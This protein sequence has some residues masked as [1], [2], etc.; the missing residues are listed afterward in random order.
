VRGSLAALFPAGGSRAACV[1]LDRSYSMGTEG[2]GGVLFDRGVKRLSAIL[3]NLESGDEVSVVLFDTSTE[4][5]YDGGPDREAVLEALRDARPSWGG[6]DLRSAAA[7]GERILARSRR[8]ARELYIVSDFQKTAFA[9]RGAGARAAAPE[10]SRAPGAPAAESRRDLPVRAFLLPVQAKGA[11]N[12]AVESVAA[13]SVALHKGETAELGITLRNRSRE[14]AAKFPLEV[15]IAGRRVLEKEIEIPP[16]GYHTEKVVF[17]AE[18]SGWIDGVVRKRPDRLSADDARYFALNV[19]D[20]TRVLLLADDGGFYLEQALV[21]GGIEGDIA[22]AKRAWR[23]F[24]SAD[25]GA[26]DAVVLGPGRGPSP[27]DVEIIGRF[28]ER[29]GKAIVFLVPELAAAAKRL[30]GYPLAIEFAEMPQGFFRLAKPE[31]PPDFLAPFDE[32]DL[33][34]FARLRFRSA[35]LVRGVPPAEARLSFEGRGPFVWEERRGEGTVVFAAADPRPEAGELVLSPFFLPLV[36]QLVLATG[37]DAPASQGSL[38]GEPIVWTG[39]T[40]GEVTCLLPD[41]AT[42]RPAGAPGGILIPSVETP[43]IVTVLA[44]G[45]PKGKI[46]VNPDCRYESDLEYLE[47][48]DAADSLGLEHRLVVEEDRSL[49]PAVHAARSGREITTP[50]LLAAMALLAAELF[51]A[52]RERGDAT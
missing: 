16:D 1:L 10:P 42:I 46:A 50:L 31:T 18:R 13:P 15:S 36:Q 39:E 33:E 49:A 47:P 37:R 41:G 3:D 29:G 6:T 2:D 25:L 20:K 23:A 7:L 28:V 14:L 21:P 5:V 30:S 32:R 52:Q 35:A 24:T 12:V 34:A 38:V 27:G 40:D 9:R 4:L 11:A 45:E 19:R 17:P 8:E 22:V 44:G 26:S 51:V 48:R 43:G